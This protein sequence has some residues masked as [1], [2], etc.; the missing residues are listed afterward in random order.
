MI[1]NSYLDQTVLLVQAMVHA[2][3]PGQAVFVLATHVLLKAAVSPA[4]AS[5]DCAEIAREL[6]HVLPPHV[7]DQGR[8]P[9]QRDVQHEVEVLANVV[10]AVEPAEAP[11]RL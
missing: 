10:G 1:D 7:A 4:P 6:G 8:D 5:A 9:L 11:I 2:C 3:L